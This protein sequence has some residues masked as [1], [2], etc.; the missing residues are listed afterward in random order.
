MLLS[1]LHA[2]PRDTRIRFH[3][4]SH[5]YELVVENDDDDDDAK[6]SFVSVTTLVHRQFPAFDADRVI[7]KMHAS[8]RWPQ[9]PYYPMTAD[10]IRAQW[11]RAGQDAA[12]RGTALHARIE[13]F[14]NNHGMNHNDDDDDEEF[15]QFLRF[16]RD[17]VVTRGLV[18]Y[19]TEWAVFDETAGVAGSVDMVYRDPHTGR[20][21]IYDWKRT[22]A[23]KTDNPYENGLPPFLHTYPHC[24]HVH[25]SLQL[26]LYREILVTRYDT[27]PIDELCLVV[28]HPNRSEAQVVPCLDLREEARALLDARRTFVGSIS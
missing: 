20:L 10:A 4:A 5:V 13:R 24:N 26:H 2:H 21:C 22:K 18:P 8:P 7:A 6:T 15:A 23:L 1:A 25:Y 14:Y 11:H 17:V 12:S 16:H 3:E 27:G 28:M 19:R 9:S